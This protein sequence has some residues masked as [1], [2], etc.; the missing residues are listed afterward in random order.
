MNKRIVLSWCFQR[1]IVGKIWKSIRL[2]NP[3]HNNKVIK[4]KGMGLGYHLDDRNATVSRDRPLELQRLQFIAPV[5]LLQFWTTKNDE[6]I[7]PDVGEWVWEVWG[8]KATHTKKL[9]GFDS[10]FLKG[11]LSRTLT[12]IIYRSCCFRFYL[13][14]SPHWGFMQ[15]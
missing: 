7:Y 1:I 15:L 3:L 4:W 9:Y 10:N 14:A 2:N 6:I 5:P 13:D 8:A 12:Q 11:K